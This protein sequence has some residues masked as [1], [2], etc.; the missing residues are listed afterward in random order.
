MPLQGILTMTSTE[1]HSSHRA[2][3]TI[4]RLA[5]HMGKPMLQ[6]SSTA[7]S[8]LQLIACLAL[9][10]CTAFATDNLKLNQR[11]DY[12]S[13]SQDG[14]LI[15]G[16]NSQAGAVSGKVNYIIMFEEG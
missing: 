12:N 1:A 11:L 8:A 2:Q 16:D 3:G 6:K 7:R 9:L 4:L 15:T 14:P 5:S 13:D 10:A